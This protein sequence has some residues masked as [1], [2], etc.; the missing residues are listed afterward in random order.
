MNTGREYFS[1]FGTIEANP[2]GEFEAFGGNNNN[3][4]L[5]NNNNNNPLSLPL[6]GFGKG[7]EGGFNPLSGGNAEG[8]DLNIAVL[9]NALTEANLEINH[10]E[11]ESNY[12]KL[13]EF[14]GIEVED[15]NKW[16]EHYNRIAEANKWS[17]HKRFQIIEG[18]LVGAAAR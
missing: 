2:F 5:E 11:R 1:H 10:T 12:V 7:L 13:T 9:V 8:L 14:E 6:P 4:P 18:Y 15:P 17:E 16:L 3:P